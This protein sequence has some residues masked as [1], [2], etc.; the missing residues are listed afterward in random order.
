MDSVIVDT[1]VTAFTYDRLNKNFYVTQTDFFSYRKGGIYNRQGTKVD[2]FMV[3]YS[4]EVIQTY[5]NTTVGLSEVL[6]Q[7]FNVNL[8]LYPNPAKEF[9]NLSW[10]ESEKVVDLEVYNQL[11]ALVYTKQ[12]HNL[13]EKVSLSNMTKGVYFVRIRAGE[14]IATQKLILE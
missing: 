9:I 11:G 14:K 10:E 3:G 2:T 5:Y 6:P 8:Y 1:V 13:L 4:P 7:K 12:N